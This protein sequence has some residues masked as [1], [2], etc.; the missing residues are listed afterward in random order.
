MNANF[1]IIIMKCANKNFS[2][3]R[4]SMNFKNIIIIIFLN[5]G[6]FLIANENPLK[7]DG[8]IVLAGNNK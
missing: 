4:V 2:F 6:N 5:L 7:S 3:E 8:I 1:D